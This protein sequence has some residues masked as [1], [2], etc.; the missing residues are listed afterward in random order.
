MAPA[1][2]TRL[3]LPLLTC[4][5]LAPAPG[6]STPPK[7]SSPSG[8]TL[9]A[10]D[11]QCDHGVAKACADASFLWDKQL[12]RPGVPRTRAAHRLERAC[13][14]GL[15]ADCRAAA[16]AVA[17]LGLDNPVLQERALG[18]AV[19]G[20]LTGG[21][22]GACRSALGTCDWF[23]TRREKHEEACKRD[24]PRCREPAPRFRCN[25]KL[26]KQLTLGS[27]DWL[28]VFEIYASRVFDDCAPARQTERPA[29]IAAC[30]ASYES[31]ARIVRTL[32]AK[33][34]HDP[35]DDVTSQPTNEDRR[36]AL[37][38][39]L[40]YMCQSLPEAKAPPACPARPRDES[41][42]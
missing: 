3:G 37:A 8:Q 14:L 6:C 30:I 19:F 40:A 42:P 27:E 22:P 11:A 25:G 35:I 4:L 12:P 16:T 36:D 15:Y 41:A 18:V 21:E 10:L 34:K 39:M 13:R 29:D 2:L 31:N 28:E 32:R 1:H 33:P 38:R 24:P 20:C 5:L 9:E 7:A 17:V 26:R 23:D